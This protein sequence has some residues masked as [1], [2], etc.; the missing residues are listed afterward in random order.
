MANKTDPIA[1]FDS[2]M[3]GIS[4]LKEMAALMPQEDFIYFGDSL[5]APYGTKTTEEVRRLTIEHI[6]MLIKEHHAKAIA[7]AC[8]T[9][10]SAAVRILREMYPEVPLVGVEPAIKPAVFDCQHP[11][12]LV[13]ATP[14]TLK[15][16]KFH[17]L[18]ALYHDRAEIYPLPCPGLM[19]FVEQGVLD[20]EE[21]KNFLIEKITPYLDKK[22][23]G[24]V[25]GC[26]HYPFVRKEIRTIVG[27][28][29]K[30]FD[31][32][33]GTARELK[34]RIAEANLKREDGHRGAVTFMN[35]SED[36]SKLELSRFLFTQDISDVS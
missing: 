16:K 22:L 19:E 31:G 21:L 6:T 23:T 8:N 32:S 2:G 14:V 15:E 3:G 27:P 10:T 33:F 34:R 7:V 5:H 13:M 1:V 9:A 20:G 35:S 28:N 4:V 18:E 17:N 26:T 24:V 29:V 11:R 36:R 25:L 30:L 12:V